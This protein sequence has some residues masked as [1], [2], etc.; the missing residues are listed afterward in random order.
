M[1]ATTKIPAIVW[2][3]IAALGIA[4]VKLALDV[5]D[6]PKVKNDLE[7][8]RAE[9]DAA[10]AEF[11]A[12]S[13]EYKEAKEKVSTL[14]AEMAA[15]QAGEAAKPKPAKKETDDALNTP[16]PQVSEPAE[17]VPAVS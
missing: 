11:G 6:M 7:S 10:K 12:Q 14:T 5:R 4:F 13:A 1:S 2:A 15:L 8:A 9:R 17:S 3:G 16:A